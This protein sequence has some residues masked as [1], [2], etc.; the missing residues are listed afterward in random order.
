MRAYVKSVGT[1]VTLVDIDSGERS[2]VNA[3]A[4]QK[5]VGVELKEGEVWEFNAA[6]LGDLEEAF[7]RWQLVQR[8]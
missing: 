1:S 5:L 8:A 4:I 6:R 7:K 3:A 2:A